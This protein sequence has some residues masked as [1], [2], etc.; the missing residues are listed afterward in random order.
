MTKSVETITRD[1]SGRIIIDATRDL[2][3][4][5]RKQDGRTAIQCDQGHCVFAEAAKREMP[6]LIEVKF[7]RQFTRLCFP[8]HVVRYK[9]SAEITRQIKN[10]DPTGT[11]D[12]GEY[13]LNAI[14]PH[15][16]LGARGGRGHDP[17]RTHETKGVQP[18][19]VR[20][21]SARPTTWSF[22]PKG[23]RARKQNVA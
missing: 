22:K 9:N 2:V 7:G 16:A 14:S 17:K 21:I 23:K 19:V 20:T 1:G 11:F 6:G 4:T 18:R 10:F 8:E 12:P 13:R 5:V 15:D 3:I